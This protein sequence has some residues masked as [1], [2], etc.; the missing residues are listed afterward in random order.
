[1]DLNDKIMGCI[2]GQTVFEIR[3]S[4]G[5][6][7]G[8]AVGSMV[9]TVHLVDTRIRVDGV[10]AMSGASSSSK[11]G[12]KVFAQNISVGNQAY[13]PSDWTFAVDDAKSCNVVNYERKFSWTDL[14]PLVV[15]FLC[16]FLVRLPFDIF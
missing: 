11:S 16:D 6:L 8:S 13:P 7:V 4:M 3:W 14:I 2:T 1:M 5:S 9:D 12:P 10:T 15:A